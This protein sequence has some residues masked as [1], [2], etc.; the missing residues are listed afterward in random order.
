MSTQKDFV[1]PNITASPSFSIFE[2]LASAS[3]KVREAYATGLSVPSS[4]WCDST[5]PN[6]RA[7]HHTKVAPLVAASLDERPLP[8]FSPSTMVHLYEVTCKTGE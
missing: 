1:I 5:A 3:A 2:Y 6:R 8:G 4:I 7:K